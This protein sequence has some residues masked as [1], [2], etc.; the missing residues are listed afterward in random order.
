MHHDVVGKVH[1]SLYL[2]HTPMTL[3][4]PACYRRKHHGVSLSEPCL[5]PYGRIERLV[6]HGL[7]LTANSTA[8]STPLLVRLTD[9]A[10]Y[11]TF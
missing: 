10:I 1:P 7:I 3:L 9:A 4:E 2:Q 6:S 8:Q 5:Q 11:L